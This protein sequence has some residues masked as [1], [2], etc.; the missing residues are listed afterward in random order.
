MLRLF[1]PPCLTVGLLLFLG[2]TV[3][4]GRVDI[5]GELKAAMR[6]AEAGDSDSWQQVQ[7]KT[8]RCLNAGADTPAVREL[9]ILSLIRT[10][11]LEKAQHKAQEAVQKYPDHFLLQY[12][13]GNATY[14]RGKYIDALKPLRTAHR[15]NP[16]N[17]NALILLADCARRQNIPDAVAYY[18]QLM[19]RQ[20]FTGVE[21]AVPLN[22][23]GVFYVQQGH[24]PEAMSQFSQAIHY[25]G[26]S[27]PLFYLNAAVMYDQYRRDTELARKFYIKFL[28]E[29]GTKFSDLTATVRNRLRQLS[30]V[31]T[32]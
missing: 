2:L 17:L 20:A 29:A 8:E 14:Q 22:E 31:D 4:C 7:K 23:L 16:E 9:H 19:T 28:L 13:L 26:N 27:N 11:Q 10:G 1:L 32:P 25:S 18:N 30:P 12:L 24:Y 21:R 15:L 3:G 5:N 6:L